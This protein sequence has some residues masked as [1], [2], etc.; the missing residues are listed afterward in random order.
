MS[1]YRVAVIPGDGVGP[2][3][4]AEAT[5][6]ADAA[7]G[8]YGFGIE[9]D[10]F[11]WSC[12]RYLERGEMMPG[13]ALDTLRPYDAGG[14]HARGHIGTTECGKLALSASS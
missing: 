11:D 2:E 8:K 12:D 6:I 4:A 1:E 10:T 3:V 14:H 7:A 13:D 5:R 9:F